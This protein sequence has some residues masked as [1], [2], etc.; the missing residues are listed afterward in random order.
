MPGQVIQSR[1]HCSRPHCSPCRSKSTAKA[2]VVSDRGHLSGPGSAHVRTCCWWSHWSQ[3]A[4]P[5]NRMEQCTSKVKSPHI[6]SG[7]VHQLETKRGHAISLQVPF[8]NLCWHEIWTAT[9]HHPII[10]VKQM[11]SIALDCLQAHQPLWGTAL[12]LCKH[13]QAL[14]G[15]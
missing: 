1:P 12:S 14:E 4:T 3:K 5:Q 8:Q 7:R 2:T 15:P 13:Y 9:Q 10:F 6:D 11:L